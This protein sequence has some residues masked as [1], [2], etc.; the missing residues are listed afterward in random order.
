MSGLLSIAFRDGD[1][2]HLWCRFRR[3]RFLLLWMSG[4]VSNH[5]SRRLLSI[6][7]ADTAL[8]LMVSSILG[9]AMVGVV[10]ASTAAASSSSPTGL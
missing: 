2:S 1:I 10:V 8:I 3:H 9:V 6:S 5:G 7:P 4:L